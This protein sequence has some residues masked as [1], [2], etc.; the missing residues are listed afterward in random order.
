M[1]AM[2]LQEGGRRHAPRHQ[3]PRR[4]LHCH[5]H[6]LAPGHPQHVLARMLS[7]A[8]FDPALPPRSPLP[9]ARDGHLCRA[10][11]CCL[12]SLPSPLPPAIAPPV[13]APLLCREERMEK[14]RK[15]REGRMT[16]GTHI[17][18][19]FFVMTRLPRGCQISRYHRQYSLGVML[20]GFNHWRIRCSRFYSLGIRIRFLPIFEGVKLDFFLLYSLISP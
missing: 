20:H 8:R 7:P 11:P 13:A 2:S 10:V 19:L 6:A 4:A 1:L 18:L 9:S 15:V 16:C 12:S 17:I 14:R 3:P 5:L